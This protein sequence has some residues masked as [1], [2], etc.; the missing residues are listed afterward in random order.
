MKFMDLIPGEF[1]WRDN[2]FVAAVRVD[3]SLSYAHIANSGRLPGLLEP[4]K[5]VYLED[6]N[7]PERRTR[8]D[9]KLVEN[10]NILISVDARLPNSLFEEAVRNYHLETFLFDD[11]QREVKFGKS[12]LDFKIRE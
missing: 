4:G 3:G 11:I 9:L 8:Y 10:D 7:K 1:V 2:R 6:V 5:R 12:R